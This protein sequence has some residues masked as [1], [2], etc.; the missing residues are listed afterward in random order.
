MEPKTEPL[1]SGSCEGYHFFPACFS[2][3][4]Y[5]FYVP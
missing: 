3:E 5:L 1:I 4:P 2:E